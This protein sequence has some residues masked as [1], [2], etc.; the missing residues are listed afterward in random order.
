MPSLDDLPPYRR[1]K[2]LWDYAHF[3][4]AG[5]E[6]M[7]RDRAGEPCHLSDVPVPESPRIAVL[8]DDGRHHLMCGSRMICAEGQSKQGWEHRQW[9]WWGQSDAG[10]LEDHRDGGTYQ[11]F[12]HEWTI[13]VLDAGV[14][15]ASV[16]VEQRCAAGE[17]GG[18]HFWP[19]PPAKTLVVLR[20][21]AALIEAL[22]LECHLCHALPG[23]MVDHD[24]A[25][26]LVRGPLTELTRAF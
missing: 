8:A 21:R 16:P 11:G 18:F 13:R 14:P 17:Y 7:V 19:P 4:V 15:P 5:V 20:L 6:Q 12:Q 23:A 3:G 2:L 22:G 10:A 1:A 25:T 26:G 9:C 24:Y